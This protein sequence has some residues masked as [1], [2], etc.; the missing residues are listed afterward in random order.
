[1]IAHLRGTVLMKT[2][3]SVVIDVNGV[4]MQVVCAPRTL[5]ALHVGAGV[6]V[7]TALVVREDSLTLYG[8][9]D[10]EERDMWHLVQTVSGIGPKVAL[11]FVSVLEPERARRALA[12]GDLATL[13][14]VPGIGRKGAERLVVE[15][16]DK[17]AVLST[18]T[19]SASAP[20]QPA[21]KE[22]L[23]SL[24]WS[25]KEAEKTVTKVADSLPADHSGDV[26][27]ILRIA[28]QSMARTR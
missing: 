14:T 5:A 18:T 11:A 23:V 16:K 9:A 6:D 24:G 19:A 1:M 22:A 10:T 3:D 15:L 26:S 28:L 8:F 7:H 25:V 27:E 4:G 12:D 2:L 20:W 21:V 13:T 17:V